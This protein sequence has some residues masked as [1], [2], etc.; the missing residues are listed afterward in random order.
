MSMT[1]TMASIRPS[2][3][4]SPWSGSRLPP[5]PPPPKAVQVNGQ[6]LFGLQKH[7]TAWNRG[8]LGSWGH[9]H[10]RVIITKLEPPNGDGPDMITSP[11]MLLVLAWPA[12][13]RVSSDCLRCLSASKLEFAV[14][15]RSLKEN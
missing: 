11:V 5:P 8:Q 3:C 2:S 4:T 10:E 13:D 1:K 12:P 15:T 7:G 14:A 9:V 6:N